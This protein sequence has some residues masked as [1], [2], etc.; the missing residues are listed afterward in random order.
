[1]ITLK[2]SDLFQRHGHD[3]DWNIRIADQN[4]LIARLNEHEPLRQYAVVLEDFTDGGIAS[5][6]FIELLLQGITKACSRH[7]I[8]VE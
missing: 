6:P 8:S 5:L 7:N 3:F 4:N 2:L 1:M